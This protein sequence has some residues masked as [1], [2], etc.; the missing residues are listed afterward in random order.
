MNY[1]LSLILISQL[2]DTPGYN[3]LMLN[4]LVKREVSEAMN[5]SEVVV[6]TMECTRM[7][8]SDEVEMLAHLH[9]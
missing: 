2:L 5:I 1:Y 7:F 3:N 8:Q 9:R 4:D 6:Y